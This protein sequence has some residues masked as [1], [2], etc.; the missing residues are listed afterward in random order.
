[1]GQRA[2][3]H[4]RRRLGVLVV[5]VVFAGSRWALW[6]AGVEFDTRPLR[7]SF[8]LVDLDLLRDDL[9]GTLAHLHTQPPLFNLAVGL[10]LKLGP[11]LALTAFH[12]GFLGLGLALALGVYAALVRAGA[13]VAT[14]SLATVALVLSPSVFL[15]E[16]WLHY[17]Y[18]VTVL[19]VLAVVALQ[20]YAERRRP[21]DAGLF[22]ALLAAV[23][24][25][26]SMFHLAWLVAW[27]TVI[28]VAARR[29]RAR[30]GPVLVAAAVAVA[31]I[32]GVYAN[33]WRV[34]GQFSASTTLGISLAKI[35]TFQ[36][37]EDVR[38]QLVASGALSP[39]ALITPASP[40]PQ[41]LG[42]VASHPP[43]GVAVLDQ[44]AKGGA[45]P[46]T[47]FRSNYNNLDYVELSDRYLD[48]ALTTVRLR[49]EAYVQG[50]IRAVAIFFRPPSEF[51]GLGPNRQLVDVLDRAYNLALLY[52]TALNEQPMAATPSSA[53]AFTPPPGGP[54]WLVVGAYAVV[55]VAGA[56]WVLARLRRRRPVLVVAFLWSTVVYVAV[57]GNLLEIGENNRFRLYT[58][59]LVLVF[60]VA[61]AVALR[62]RRRHPRAPGVTPV[63]HAA[64]VPATTAAGAAPG[65]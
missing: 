10:G 4:R 14:A 48:D 52:L 40:L 59:P 9:V 47:P 2:P 27:A 13:G 32:A 34:S 1:M 24:L 29:E 21:L 35:T 16:Y 28:V 33:S 42:L 64:P 53:D 51:F 62:R 56:A 3:A 50:V 39:L 46:A 19:L 15:Y 55:V 31:A 65:R 44:A 12:L 41:Y 25:T 58:D 26:R 18:P 23:C 20:R 49:P 36:L 11:S 38:R 54:A 30:F 45:D 8:A 37:G 22:L 63:C 60:V 17:D 6:A 7:N 57:V 5:V 61:L 43:T